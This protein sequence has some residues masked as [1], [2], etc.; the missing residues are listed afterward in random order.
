[1]ATQAHSAPSVTRFR[2]KLEWKRKYWWYTPLAVQLVAML[3][4][5]TW[6]ASRFALTHDFALYWQ[7]VYL[8]AHGHLNPYSTVGGFPYLDNHFELIMWPL[9]FL[10]WLW[11]RPTLL[12]YLQDG[13]LVGAGW[14]AWLWMRALIARAP[15]RY[16]VALSVT[17][18]TL[19]V[20][21]PW[22]YW[23]AAFDFHTEA[24]VALTITGVAY[25]LWR[26][27]GRM[28]VLWA[29]LTLLC[30]DVAAVALFAV[31]LT[32]MWYRQ[33]RSA[34][35]LA[36][37]SLAWL[38]IIS[39]LHGNQGSV[40]TP[41]YGYLAQ[42]Q[43]RALIPRRFSMVTV[44]LLL[45]HHPGIGLRTLIRHGWNVYANAGPAGFAGALTP[46][47]LPLYLATVIVSNL[48]SYYLF[49]APGFQNVMVYPVL[50]VG[51]VLVLAWVS[52]RTRRRLT[53]SLVVLVLANSLG[54]A[55]FWLPALPVHWVRVSAQ[56]ATNLAEGLAAIP[57]SAQ[58]V[59]NQSIMGR[60]A[61]RRWIS[62][63]SAPGGV[64][65]VHTDPFYVAVAPY[66]GVHF[67]SVRGEASI[68][69]QLA[70]DPH[71]SLVWFGAHTYLWKVHQPVGSTFTLDTAQ[72]TNLPAWAF[73]TQTGAP[74]VGSAPKHWYIAGLG[75]NG[76]VLDQAYWR[77]APGLLHATVTYSSVGPLW[78]QVWNA[79]TG[80]LITQRYV[81]TTSGRKATAHLA[82]WYPRSF[83]GRPHVYAGLGIWRIHA[84]T[85]HRRNEL[86][87]RVD[88]QA[89][90][91]VNVYAVGLRR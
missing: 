10:Y 27:N 8:I 22:V 12:L 7:A 42:H 80:K 56:A 3:A 74:V 73:S 6:Q 15:A 72:Q 90:S 43:D 50:A 28:V 81:P 69:N 63:T 37:A 24:F 23:A 71:A 44:L 16:C 77:E 85:G 79:T 5:S 13:A 32:A 66:A 4:F 75:H 36:I 26:H 76:N 62:Q 31:A 53:L 87:I 9:S 29:A 78:L 41:L 65:S 68:L 58:V 86:E 1:M 60:F 18:L 64:V 61:G 59:A 48:T 17:G 40:L 38:E 57:A 82:I 35:G 55:A 45:L 46:W 25:A 11:P 21:N 20:L 30:G 70:H 33:W 39:V 14:I 88:A 83:V 49:G 47:G 84:A 2:R 51:C 19:L 34:I 54:W 89:A 52:R 67:L 91:M